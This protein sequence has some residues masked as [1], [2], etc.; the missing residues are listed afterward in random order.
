MYYTVRLWR[1]KLG[2]MTVRQV[3]TGT[4]VGTA[5]NW[6]CNDWIFIP[7]IFAGMRPCGILLIVSELFISESLSQVYGIL[8]EFLQRNYEA[9]SSLSEVTLCCMWEITCH[10]VHCRTYLLW[11]CLPFTEVYQ[12]CTMVVTFWPIRLQY[13]RSI[14]HLLT[15]LQVNK[16]LLTY[17]FYLFTYKFFTRFLQAFNWQMN[18]NHMTMVQVGY[19]TQCQFLCDLYSFGPSA[20]GV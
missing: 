8:H 20:L 7:G 15:S 17:K 1:K 12:N 9:A 16:Y 2:S 4:I 3:Y 13:R 10:C 11:W 5:S 6:L 19:I 14:N 18:R